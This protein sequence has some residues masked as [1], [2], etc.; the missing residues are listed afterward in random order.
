MITDDAARFRRF[1]RAVFA[2]HAVVLKYGD[3]AN[4]PFGQSSA[5]WRVLFGASQGATT[6]AAI[7]RATGY[8][9][10]AIQRL[11]DALVS[12]GL[13]RYCPDATDRRTQ[14]IELTEA[15]QR[16]LEQLEANFDMWAARLLTQI[17][18]ANLE[19]AC[20]ALERITAVVQADSAYMQRKEQ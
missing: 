11:A 1:T 18:A 7:A 10:Q 3:V 12:E 13:A 2:A 5:R 14:R 4:A 15:G 20:D 16:T 6:V 8:S 19:V 17:G 9:R